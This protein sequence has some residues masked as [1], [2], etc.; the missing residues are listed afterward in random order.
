M[1][2]CVRERERER[3]RK[4]EGGREGGRKKESSVIEQKQFLAEWVIHTFGDL[5]LQLDLMTTD[6]F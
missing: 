2:V 1:C 6:L 5:Q 3:G 4:R